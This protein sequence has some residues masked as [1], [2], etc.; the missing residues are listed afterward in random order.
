M[1]ASLLAHR[2]R[3]GDGNDEERGR[4]RQAENADER[5][6]EKLRG[7]RGR[8]LDAHGGSR[9]ERREDVPLD[10]VQDRIHAED[11]ERLAVSW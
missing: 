5:S 8:R 3:G 9:E 11:R 7:E 6:E 10:D 4:K 2:P 1:G